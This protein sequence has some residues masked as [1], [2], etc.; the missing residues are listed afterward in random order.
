LRAILAREVLSGSLQRDGQGYRLTP[1]G[2]RVAV[3]LVRA[4]RLWEQYLINQA[5]VAA[6]RIH[7]HAEQFEHVADRQIRDELERE[8][9]FP[10]SDP[11]G[12]PI[13]GEQEP[14]ATDRKR[15]SDA[16]I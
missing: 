14:P 1:D 11:H 7:D 2:H 3:N 8:T 13:P 4:H 12:S 6:D 5:G 10:T 15:Q 16:S 9:E